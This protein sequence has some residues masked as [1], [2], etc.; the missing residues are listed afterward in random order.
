MARNILNRVIQAAI[1]MLGVA[2]L[3]FIMLRI[4]PGNAIVTMMGEHAKLETIE[5][6]TR[7]LGLD[8]PIYV[9]FWRYISDAVRG[10]FG[11]SYSLNRSVTELIGVAFP[12]TCLLYTSDAA[13]EL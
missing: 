11:T 12:N 13:D 6:M 3:I 7:E 10:D 5:R 4:V 1:V 9:Q 2:L 8:Q